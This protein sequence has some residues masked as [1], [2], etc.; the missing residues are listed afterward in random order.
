LFIKAMHPSGVPFEIVKKH[1]PIIN[2]EIEK[3]LSG[4]AEFNVFMEAE[5]DRLDIFIEHPEQEA[6]PIE[7]GSGAEKMMASI[8]IRLALI[9]VCSLPKNDTIWLDEPATAM[10]AKNLEMF[11]KLLEMLKTQ[12]RTVFLIT[13]LEQLKDSVDFQILLDRNE[14]GIA[15]INI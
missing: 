9:N 14:E 5:S 12:F 3:I 13:H 11:T 2:G 1:L 15:H 4:F 6:R 7:L 8:A 10:D